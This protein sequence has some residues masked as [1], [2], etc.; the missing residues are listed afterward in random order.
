MAK[1]NLSNLVKRDALR[2]VQRET[3]EQIHDVIS[4]T[5]GPYGSYSM[6][7]HNDQL[8]DYSKDGHKVLSNFKFYRPLE[9]SIHDELI[10]ITDHVIKKVGDGTTTAIQLSHYIFNSLC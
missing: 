6:I 10:G 2:K 5:A 4:N 8:T 3:L 9:A 7:M 1:S